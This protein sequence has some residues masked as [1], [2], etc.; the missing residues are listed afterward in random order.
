M[1]DASIRS[2]VLLLVPVLLV[3]FLF[4]SE[5]LEAWV[6]ADYAAEGAVVVRWL[7][8]GLLFN[9]LAQVPFALVQG[10]GRPDITARFHLLEVP[11]F[12]ALLWWALERHGLA[13]AASAWSFRALLDA[14]LLFWAARRLL[15]D[16]GRGVK[17]A[18]W[19]GLGG[20]AVLG[21]GLVLKPALGGPG[22]LA[23][24]VTG[25][26]LA[27]WRWLLPGG[28][29][30]RNAL[31][32]ILKPGAMVV[33]VSVGF[34]T[35][36]GPA[37]L[38]A[39]EVVNE[40]RE[41]YLRLLGVTGR[42]TPYPWGLRGLSLRE[43]RLLAPDSGDHPW[44]EQL[45]F[46]KPQTPGPHFRLLPIRGQTIFNSTFPQG[47]NDGPLWAGKGLTGEIEFG[48]AAEWG[49]ISL[50]V[51]PSAFWTQNAEFEL[52]ETGR[53]GP[54][55]FADG[56]RPGNID[57]PQRFGEAAYARIN[58]GESALR[59]DSR[60]VTLGVSTAS[61]HW[62]PAR[63]YPLLLG[64]NA[65][66]YP[67][68]FLG[69]GSP[70]DAGIGTFHFRGVWGKL[71]QSDFSPAV[72]EAPE[73]L[74]SGAVL[75]FSPRGIEGLE[76]GVGRL[77]HIAWKDG[78]PV[79]KDFLRPF[80]AFLKTGLEQSELEPD[81]TI[82]G[83]ENQVA[84]FFARWVF[85]ES[86]LEVY[87]ESY[88]EDHSWDLRDF[89][90]EPDHIDGLTVGFQKVWERSSREWWTFGGELLNARVSHLKE[91]RGE[92]PPYPHGKIRQ[93]HTHL[94]QMLGS[95]AAYGGSGGILEAA[96][97]TPSG[98]WRFWW[99]RAQRNEGR[100]EEGRWVVDA[101]HSL[102]ASVLLFRGP[103]EISG[104]I[105]GTWN[106]NRNLGEDAW[107]LRCQVGG[108]YVFDRG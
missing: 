103:F 1:F 75:I 31:K 99:E 32:R 51:A 82:W 100:K 3:L 28:G 66:G 38:V 13:G 50:R 80:E 84:S 11:I 33:V 77:F 55:A 45:N 15:P 108:G 95:P 34:S 96:R 20:A 93:G 41:E 17:T 86:G 58:P 43:I 97:I 2:I 64:N 22:A 107:N 68:V 90:M 36:S 7:A 24:L 76:L 53:D 98:S 61:Q 87:L 67:H 25:F 83:A 49:P 105:L 57:A 73:R 94:G 10:I 23:L 74:A 79:V 69:T 8:I 62:G 16:T 14:V 19:W 71:G 5:G 18:M 78:G 70:V 106:L 72:P 85:P 46:E 44:A 4:A 54:L 37:P 39:Q 65:G 21:L 91:I 12:L 81:T 35:M 89:L 52:L 6:G 56:R 40:P 9:G 63:R 60:W 29:N 26:G 104:G 27:A 48:G 102:G 101:Q 59:F 42:S 47:E 30:L 92:G 88:H